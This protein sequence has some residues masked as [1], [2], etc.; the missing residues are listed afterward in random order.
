MIPYDTVL[1]QMRKLRFKCLYYNSGAFGFA[2]PAGVKTIAWTGPEDPTI[3]PAAL[4]FVRRIRAPY[5]ATL[6]RL[7]SRLWEQSL[8]GR[9]WLMPMSHWAFELGHGSHEWLPTLFKRFDLDSGILESCNNAAAIEFGPGETGPFESF[10]E[11]LL[12]MLKSSDF[13]LAFPGRPV[14]CT[15]HHHKQLWWQTTDPEAVAAIEAM[16]AGESGSNPL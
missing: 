8:P 9:A 10:V 12:E 11:R 14:L 5:E 2:D 1:E 15:V 13:M 6:A 16:T 4:P 3:R 7:V